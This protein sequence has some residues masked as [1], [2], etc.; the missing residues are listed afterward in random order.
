MPDI[1]EENYVG[2]FES[3]DHVGFVEGLGTEDN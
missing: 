1:I 3:T 2:F